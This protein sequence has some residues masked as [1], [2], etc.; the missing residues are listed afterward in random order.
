MPIAF[1]A[2]LLIAVAVHVVLLLVILF[3]FAR[4]FRLWVAAKVAGFPITLLDLF[5]MT[6]R[7]CNPKV[8]VETL[9]MVKQA[10]VLLSSVGVERAYLAGADLQKISAA[11]VRGKAEGMEVSFQDLVETDLRE[12]AAG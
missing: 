6:F 4:F 3:V 8:V 9:I 12:N 1:N 2:V 11:L 7:K 5:G 10:G